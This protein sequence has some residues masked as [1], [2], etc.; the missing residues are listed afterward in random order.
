M[1]ASLDQLEEGGRRLDALQPLFR[2]LGEL[3]EEHG[4]GPIRSHCAY[5]NAYKRTA[6]LSTQFAAEFVERTKP[7]ITRQLAELDAIDP[8]DAEQYESLVR[9]GVQDALDRKPP[10]P[11]P[12][13]FPLDLVAT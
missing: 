4:P 13:G 8:W 11:A 7:T 1:Q 9:R 3:M 12:E 2:R 5:L 10:A 6:A